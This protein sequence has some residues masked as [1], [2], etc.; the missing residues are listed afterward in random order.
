MWLNS[1]RLDDVGAQL[2][3]EV[4]HI[5]LH[6]VRARIVIEAPHLV[7]QLALRHHLARVAHEGLE[8]R[9]LAG[10]ELDRAVTHA[11]LPAREVQG[12]PGARQ[13]SGSRLVGHAKAGA[14]ACHELR[15][16]ERL[17]QVVFGAGVEVGHTIGDGV[18]GG[19]DDD[20]HGAARTAQPAEHL[21]AG[22]PR[23][24]ETG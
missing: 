1:D 5:D 16:A 10:G 4:S 22:K 20:R 19:Q 14:D 9:E 23:Q 11:H 7:Q 24:D 17:D 21:L 6:D 2:P 13:D 15:E 18:L 12:D 3:T 8:Q